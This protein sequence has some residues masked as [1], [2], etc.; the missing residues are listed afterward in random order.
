MAFTQLGTVEV[1]IPWYDAN[2]LRSSFSGHNLFLHACVTTRYYFMT[3]TKF[4]YKGDLSFLQLLVY[5]GKV[6]TYLSS[7]SSMYSIL[8]VTSEIFDDV[9][10]ERSEASNNI[11]N[12]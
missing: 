8:K 4:S 2:V 5:L 7:N 3:Y 10:K 1:L 12:S 6:N 9:V 11:R